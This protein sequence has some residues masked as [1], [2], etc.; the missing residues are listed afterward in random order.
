M[1]FKIVI[2]TIMVVL[3]NKAEAEVIGLDLGNK[4]H[5]LPKSFKYVDT[6]GDYLIL[7]KDNS[8]Y[9]LR[10]FWGVYKSEKYINKKYIS[11]DTKPITK[12]LVKIN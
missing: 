6:K 2:F 9:K 3:A 8:F 12:Y 11:Y 10:G 7:K 4:I 1:I 5:I